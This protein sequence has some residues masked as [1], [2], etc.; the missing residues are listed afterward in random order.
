MEI[1][2]YGNDHQLIGQYHSASIS[3]SDTLYM[4]FTKLFLLQSPEG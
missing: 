4:Y 2:N 1:L 3:Q